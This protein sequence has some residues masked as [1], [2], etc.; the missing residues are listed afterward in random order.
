MKKTKLL[1]I[2]PVF[3]LLLSSCGGLGVSK[4]T[5]IYPTD[6]DELLDMMQGF[7]ALTGQDEIVDEYTKSLGIAVR[8]DNELM[9]TFN[10]FESEYENADILLIDAD[11]FEY[12]KN[13]KNVRVDIYFEERDGYQ[14]MIWEEDGTDY[15]YEKTDINWYY[16]YE[17]FNLS[18]TAY[19]SSVY[20]EDMLTDSELSWYISDVT[21]R[22]L[23]YRYADGD[24][25]EMNPHR[26][27]LNIEDHSG[28][29]RSGD[30]FNE[31][32][33]E[34]DNSE[35]YFTYENDETYYYSIDYSYDADNGYAYLYFN[36][37]GEGYEGCAWIFYTLIEE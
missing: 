8:I 35:L 17:G 22:E 26:I 4:E 30:S 11:T 34:V 18:K 24:T 7:W 9:N 15:Y 31:I 23:Y 28:T 1:I 37:L 3:M 14:L 29:Y 2:L 6:E 25:A 21:W 13:E 16:M 33:W 12:K 36:D 20:L 10:N 27:V 5:K 32:E 19:D